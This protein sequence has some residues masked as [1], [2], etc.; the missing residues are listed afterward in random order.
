MAILSRAGWSFATA[1]LIA[2]A[3]RVQTSSRYF[4]SLRGAALAI[5]ESVTIRRAVSVRGADQNVFAAE[6]P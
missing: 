4:G 2:S 1:S 6:C 3:M 5:R